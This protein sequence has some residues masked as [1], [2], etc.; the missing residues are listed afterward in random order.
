MIPQKGDGLLQPLG[1]GVLR[2]P[3]C[4]PLDFL[5]AAQKAVDLALFRAQPLFV[6]HDFGGGIDLANQLL[7]QI[8]SPRVLSDLK[9]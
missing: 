2:S 8:S 7:R 9:I 5:I 3:V 4:Q 6:A 1:Q